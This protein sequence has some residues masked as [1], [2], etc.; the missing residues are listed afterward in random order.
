MSS[1]SDLAHVSRLLRR[2]CAAMSGRSDG[3]SERGV[4]G[5]Q[6][7]SS[8]LVEV[9]AMRAGREEAGEEGAV[10]GRSKAAAAG[11]MRGGGSSSMDSSSSMSSAGRSE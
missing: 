9:V 7:V 1:A 5:P 8:V 11:T 10:E 2:L 4:D 6:E 3:V